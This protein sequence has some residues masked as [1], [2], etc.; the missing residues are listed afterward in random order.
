MFTLAGGGVLLIRKKRSTDRRRLLD[1]RGGYPQ[2]FEHSLITFIANL[3]A[4][5]SVAEIRPF[6]NFTPHYPRSAGQ[7]GFEHSPITSIRPR[8]HACDAG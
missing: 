6:Q 7:A 1:L 2:G 8:F 3:A 4:S 5:P